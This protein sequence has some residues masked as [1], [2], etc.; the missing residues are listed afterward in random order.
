[1]EILIDCRKINQFAF[2]MHIV[3]PLINECRKN[4]DVEMSC[5]TYTT[6]HVCIE[7]INKDN[8]IS[9]IEEED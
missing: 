6:G 4:P 5:K 9:T 1:M 8:A 2:D 3:E 7:I